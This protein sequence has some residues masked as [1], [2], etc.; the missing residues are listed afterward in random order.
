MIMVVVCSQPSSKLEDV[1]VENPKFR[2]ASMFT[3]TH[4]VMKNADEKC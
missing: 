3:H 2:R 4:T 1:P